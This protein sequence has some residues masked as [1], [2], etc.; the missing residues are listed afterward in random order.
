MSEIGK[1]MAIKPLD[2]VKRCPRLSGLKSWEL[3][4]LEVRLEQAW[5][6]D[7]ATHAENVK[8]IDHN[9]TMR[10]KIE[11]FMIAAGVPDHFYGP[12]PGSRA[13]PPKKIKMEA[14][15]LGDLKRTFPISDGFADV[16]RLYES[17]AEQ[18]TKAK[19]LVEKE[20]DAARGEQERAVERRKA[21][22]FL[23]AIK[24]RHGMP[25]ETDWPDALGLLCKKC[26]YLDLA[27][28]GLQTRG[29]WSDGF[30]RVEAALKRFTIES[31]QDKDIAADLT[32]CLRRGE[33]G[34]RDGRIFRDTEWS[35]DKLWTLVTD[36]QLLHDARTCLENVRDAHLA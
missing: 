4:G 23:V 32:G 22:L 9:G 2:A 25:D 26:K 20:R 34:D 10:L 17:L 15:Y 28:A 24:V 33:D 14:G 3:S 21:D 35:Y 16:Q 18:L 30:Y 6:D 31:D 36:G 27:V 12:K 19:S 8:A 11:A 13:Y 1:P 7:Q 29:D 5:K